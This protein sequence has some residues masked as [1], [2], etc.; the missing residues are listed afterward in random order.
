MST[1]A[2]LPH[3]PQARAPG[4]AGDS[5]G[6]SLECVDS[7]G[8]TWNFELGPQRIVLRSGNDLIDLPGESWPQDIYITSRDDGYIIRFETFDRALVFSLSSDEAAPLLH[9]LG[10]FRKS[11]DW[12][13]VEEPTPEQDGPLLW[14]KVSPL[15]IWALITSALAFVPILGLMPA[16]AAFALLLLHRQ[17]VRRSRAWD[18]SRAVCLAAGCFLITG[19]IASALGTWGIM[20][21]EKTYTAPQLHDAGTANAAPGAREARAAQ[22][23]ALGGSF[24]ANHNWG[25]IAAGL[26]VILLSLTVHEAG[27]AVTAWWLGDDLARRMG[28]VTL[29]PRAHIDPFGTVILPLILF[30]ANAGVFGWA[31]PVPVR[32]E[33]LQRP[34]RGHIL[35][36]IAGPG[37]NLLLA[38]AS[39]S[40][41]MILGCAVAM[42]FPNATV[43][44]F[45]N[46]DFTEKVSASGFALAWGLGPLCTILKL[47]FVI[48]VFLAFFNLIPIPPLDGSW[49][50]ENLFPHTLG[51]I[52]DTIRPYGFLLFLGLI[53][54]GVL[55]WLLYPAITV[56]K[57]GFM[58]LASC[59]PFH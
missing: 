22:A 52:Y 14:P 30:L 31:R 59:T 11:H 39:M 24:F 58:I 37:A 32:T 8:R 1:G 6:S 49:V 7:S 17:R 34:R 51:R 21:R 35:I 41:L 42:V 56:L 36:S 48:N 12:Q 2:G 47:S 16:A 38:A 50:L 9:H 13:E 26:V 53:Y 18:H 44:N 55:P 45:A 20:T 15:A 43:T 54:T 23:L 25:L 33:V 46:P 29:D 3:K 10:T 40:L 5:G 4:G 57:P 27:H 19:L 28:R